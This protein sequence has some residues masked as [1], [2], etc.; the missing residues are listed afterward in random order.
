[1]DKQNYT[2]PARPALHAGLRAIDNSRFFVRGLLDGLTRSQSRQIRLSGAANGMLCSFLPLYA[3]A[4]HNYQLSMLLPEKTSI[5]RSFMIHQVSLRSCLNHNLYG[6]ASTNLSVSRHELVS[7]YGQDC[8]F[9]NG[10]GCSGTLTELRQERNGSYPSEWREQPVGFSV[11][12][13]GYNPTEK[14][15]ESYSNVAQYTL[16]SFSAPYEQPPCQHLLS[17]RAITLSWCP[18]PLCSRSTA[19]RCAQAGA[20]QVTRSRL[21]TLEVLSLPA[22]LVGFSIAESEVLA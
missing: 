3:A 17:Q 20:E 9:T 13:A 18:L 11:D 15:R 14:T 12:R 8:C 22:L 2:R 4:I 10:R 21:D 7:L 19:A 1:M 6:Q 16:P 5:V